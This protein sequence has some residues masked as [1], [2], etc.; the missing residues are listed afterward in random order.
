MAITIVKLVLTRQQ[1]N[2]INDVC[3]ASALAPIKPTCEND[4]YNDFESALEGLALCTYPTNK[5]H[6][7]CLWKS[8]PELSAEILCPTNGDGS[9][10][11]DH[12]QKI[13]H[14]VNTKC[15]A[16]P[17]ICGVSSNP[18]HLVSITFGSRELFQNILSGQCTMPINSSQII[19]FANAVIILEHAEHLKVEIKIV[20]RMITGRGKFNCDLK[21]GIIPVPLHN[22]HYDIPVNFAAH[23]ELHLDHPEEILHCDVSDLNVPVNVTA[24]NLTGINVKLDVNNLHKAFKS[25]LRGSVSDSPMMSAVGCFAATVLK[26]AILGAKHHC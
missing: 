17:F 10:N 20:F 13:I 9:I 12:M 24:F 11:I 16:K 1:P 22:I 25:E 5:I 15:F 14:I 8:C 21:H 26:Q 7:E 4:T 6:H 2:C 18:F 3:V 19:N 23:T